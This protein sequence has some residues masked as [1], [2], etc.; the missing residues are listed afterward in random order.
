MQK[1]CRYESKEGLLLPVCSSPSWTDPWRWLGDL[2]PKIQMRKR[3]SSRLQRQGTHIKVGMKNGVRSMVPK[4]DFT[5]VT[6]S[7]ACAGAVEVPFRKLA[8]IIHRSGQRLMSKRQSEELSCTWKLFWFW[9]NARE[10]SIFRVKKPLEKL[11]QLR[12]H[13]CTAHIVQKNWSR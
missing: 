10:L 2:V 1:I 6:R 7:L 3:I 12:R 5:V 13:T 8:R 11:S 4:D 9:E